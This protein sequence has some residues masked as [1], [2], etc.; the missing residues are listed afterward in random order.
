M[1]HLRVAPSGQFL[2]FA[3]HAPGGDDGSVA[4]I[5]RNGKVQARSQHYGSVQGVA[6]LAH[7][8]EVWFTAAP[9]GA[10]RALYAMNM[11]GKERM[12]LRVPSI[13]TLHDISRDG[14]VLLGK[15]DAQVGMVARGPGDKTDRDISWFDWSLML[16][17][18]KDGKNVLFC[19]TGEAVG[20]RYGIY[21]RKIDGSPAIRLGDG[22]FADLSPDGKWAVATDL[23]TPSQLELLPTGVGEP[24]VI[25][26][27]KI[28]HLFPVWHPDG[29][30]V[31]FV[32]Q[33]AGHGRRTYVYDV[34]AGT[35]RAVTPE[36]T[37]GFLISPEGSRLLITANERDFSVVALDGGGSPKP[38]KGLLPDEQPIQWDSDNKHLLVSARQL[39]VTVFRLDPDSGQRQPWKQL[40]GTDPAGVESIATIRF[41]AT[42]DTYAYSYYRVLSELYVVEG[43]K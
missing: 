7:G 3:D 43:L 11:S 20:A 2:A 34:D 33:E 21:L 9:F 17:L 13:L 40:T 6:R 23:Q 14:R 39:P 1:S 10:E 32:G 31:F 42:G 4:I 22:A 18:S 35:T 24:R 27:D 26:H 19:E 30:H 37:V 36:G 12:V 28:E 15:D 38:V 41:D 5:D 25:T 29:K 16:A 8:R